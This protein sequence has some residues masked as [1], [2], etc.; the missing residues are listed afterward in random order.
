MVRFGCWIAWVGKAEFQEIYQ[1][2]RGDKVALG[3]FISSRGAKDPHSL[4][5]TAAKVA[6]VL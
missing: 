6:T 1:A 5:F 4:A 2:I 3:L